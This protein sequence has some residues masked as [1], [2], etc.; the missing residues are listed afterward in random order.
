MENVYETFFFLKYYGGWSFFE[1]YNL[2]VGL[3]K[4][5]A[6]RLA[7]QLQKESEAAEGKGGKK[8]PSKPSMPSRPSMP[9]VSKPSMPSVRR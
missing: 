3:R 8:T 2:P 6:D 9:S 5:F 4:W 7:K 1:A